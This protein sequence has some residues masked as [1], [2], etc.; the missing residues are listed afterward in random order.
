V[1]CS[2][3]SL[4]LGID[5]S[6]TVHLV[7]QPKLNGGEV[8]SGQICMKAAR[9]CVLQVIRVPWEK[10]RLSVGGRHWHAWSWELDAG[11]SCHCF[12]TLAIGTAAGT[13]VPER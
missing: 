5:G 10:Q 1:G 7:L 2:A 13:R 8:V 4:S 11:R 6:D 12:S 9:R 3:L